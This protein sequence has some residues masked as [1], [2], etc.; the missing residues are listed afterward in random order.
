MKEQ[1]MYDGFD[2]IKQKEYEKQLIDRFGDKVKKSFA[3]CEQNVKNWTKTDWDK[4]RAAFDAI[5][6]ALAERIEK[7]DSP[8]SPE[9]QKLV[10]QHYQWLKQFWTPTKES[11]PSHGRLIVETELRKPF[12]AH[13]PKLPEFLAEAMGIF[14][15]KELS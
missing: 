6:T 11:Y 8:N 2:P 9:V 3:E 7:Q 15:E 4:S 13:H 14:A 5:C 12:E 1:E 10:R